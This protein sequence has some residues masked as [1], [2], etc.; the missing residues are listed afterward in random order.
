MSDSELVAKE[1][2][3]AR[4]LGVPVSL[5]DLQTAGKKISEWALKEASAHTVFVRDTP[6][7]ML[8]SEQ[9]DLLA[10][11]EKANLVVADG[12]PL[13]WIFR[14]RGWGS[15]IGRVPGADLLDFVCKLSLSTGQGH[16]FYG[17]QATVAQTMADLLL[18]KYPGL[19]IAGVCSPPMLDIGPNFELTG[20]NLQEVERIRESRADFVWVGMS[21]PKQEYWIG[22]AA[23]IVG[24]GVFIGVGAAFDFHSG[25]VRRAPAWMRNH[26][27][28][29]FYRLLREPRRLWRRYLV[30]AP[31]FVFKALLELIRNEDK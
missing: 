22:K 4:I 20:P 16:F 17:G 5:V 7:L 29:W 31:R 8:I 30:L 14:M 13:V 15:E 10:L 28:E 9:P 1:V 6:S 23:P 3:S 18:A 26:G 11:H 19:K 12:T 2:R 24:K 27:L 21:S 25:R